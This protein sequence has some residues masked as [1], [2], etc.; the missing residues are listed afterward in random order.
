[1]SL[2]GLYAATRERLPAVAERLPELPMMAFDVLEQAK[3]GRLKVEAH[4]PQIDELRREIRRA[5]RRTVLAVLGG[6]FV[7]SA[8][9]LLALDGFAPA[10]LGRAPFSAWILGGLGVAMIAALLSDE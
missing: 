5:G 2:K 10:M 1:M 8:S 4:G 9:V 3:T 7:V 6:A